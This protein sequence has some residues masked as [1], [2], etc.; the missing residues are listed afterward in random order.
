MAVL[1]ENYQHLQ[2]KI[3]HLQVGIQQKTGG[4]QIRSTDSVTITKDTTLYAHWSFDK[5]PISIETSVDW[6]KE[7]VNWKDCI[8][9]GNDWV[10]YTIMFPCEGYMDITS[11][12][13]ESGASIKVY[14]NDIL[15]MDNEN[16]TNKRI[17]ISPNSKIEIIQYGYSLLGIEGGV[18]EKSLNSFVEKVT[19]IE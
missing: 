2:E 7:G 1:M 13:R 15:T 12:I 11:E 19:I 17:K 3:T 8:V 16:I 10:K 5:I 14:I 6:I 18:G 9:A 4:T